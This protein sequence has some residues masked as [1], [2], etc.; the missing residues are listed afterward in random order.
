MSLLRRFGVLGKLGVAAS[1]WLTALAGCSTEAGRDDI[2]GGSG[3]GPDGENQGGG[4]AVCAS[5]QP[6]DPLLRRLTVREFEATLAEAFPEVAGSW[7]SSLS[8]DPISHYGYDNAAERLLVSKQKAREIDGTAA[9]LASAVSDA[10]TQLLPCAA[11]SPDRACAEAFLD[12]YGKRLFRRP[13]QATDKGKLLGF[14]DEALA[15]TDFAEAIGWLTRALVHSPHTVYRSEIGVLADGERKLT[16]HEVA[17]AL[18]YTFGGGPPSDALLARA[19]AGELSSPEVLVQVARDLIA[20]PKG[21]ENLHH[22]FGSWLG[23]SRVTSLT[24]TNVPGF[25]AVR[26]DMREETR[27]FIELVV[28]D[29]GGGLVELLTSPV[30]T[31]S[32][33]LAQFYGFPA[34]S[35]DFQSIERPETGGI[36]ILAQGSVLATMASPDGS[37]PTKRGLLVMENFL[38]RTPP[39]VPADVPLL[40]EP[41]VGQVTTRQRY[42]EVHSVGG[43]K[44]CH[45]M[46]DP[47]GFGFEHFDEVGRYRADEGG[48]TIDASGEV[49]GSF[50]F[51]GQRELAELLALE[52]E[53]QTCVSARVKAYAFGTEGACLGE[54]QRVAFMNGAI[55]F[56]DYIASLAAEPHFVRRKPQ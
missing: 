46:F 35:A 3:G 51:S 15:K 56:V 9:S 16:Q 10:V 28:F 23:Y 38:C 8:S 1:L 30:T 50:T 31:P 5:S 55:G 11:S 47:I 14:F 26:A 40:P 32:Q 25:D 21:R 19:D 52:E 4:E 24:K 13:L 34:P 33:A 29:N 39:E 45:R 43:C 36:G 49:P 6:G 22:L 54:T 41:Q 18:A 27:R 42:E 44:N 37:S 7:T 2:G 20:T 53:M 17:S 48:L 12:K